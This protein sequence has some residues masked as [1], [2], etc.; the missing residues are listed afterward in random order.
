MERG[1]PLWPYVLSIGLLAVFALA[2]AWLGYA[3]TADTPPTC[4]FDP[5]FEWSADLAL[6]H[7]P[8]YMPGPDNVQQ[9]EL[10]L[11]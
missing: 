2:T 10:S 7:S 5:G 11:H 4:P 6:V 3:C 1:A 8:G 9:T